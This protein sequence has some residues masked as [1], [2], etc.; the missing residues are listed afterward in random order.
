MP[1]QGKEV[2]PPL[3]FA[4]SMRRRRRKVPPAIRHSR[5]LGARY[6]A[7]STAEYA[8]SIFRVRLMAGH[9]PLEHGIGVRVPD[10]EQAILS[11]K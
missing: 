5:G 11:A 7:P 9:M 2:P 4:F 10:P 3:R 1:S 6:R 8:P